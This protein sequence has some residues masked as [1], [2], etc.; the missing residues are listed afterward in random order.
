MLISTEETIATFTRESS[1]FKEFS[2]RFSNEYPKYQKYHI[3]LNL[4]SL[5]Q[6]EVNDLL[7]FLEISDNHRSEKK[8]FVLVTDAVV[9]DDIPEALAVVPTLQEAYDLIEMEEIERD[10]DF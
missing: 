10:L 4:F 9:I 6:L 3:I 8:S 1:S 2:K 5:D 7:E